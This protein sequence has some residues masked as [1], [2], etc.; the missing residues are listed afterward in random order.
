MPYKLMDPYRHK[1][2]KA[3]YHLNNWPAY[4]EALKSRGNLTIWFTT[5]IVK[6]WYHKLPGKRSPGRQNTA[7]PGDL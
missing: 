6:S 2:K 5:D 7:I 3:Q 4:N 1:F